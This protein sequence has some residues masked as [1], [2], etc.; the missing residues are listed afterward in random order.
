MSENRLDR[1]DVWILQA[2]QGQA[3]L[4]SAELAE[5]VA[6][7]PSPCWRRVKR[8]EDEGYIRGY[9]TELNPAKL[10]F[11]VTAFV[12][13]MLE[14]HR[15]DLGQEFEAAVAEVPQILSCHNVTGRYDFLL[16]VVAADLASF[17]DFARQVLR[18]LPGVKEVYSSFSLRETKAAGRLP[19]DLLLR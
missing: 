5:K 4:S 8:L 3:R 1:T 12:S 10:G 2:L 15:V 11:G 14:N 6:L 7:T 19:L 13:V 9:R 18:A 17:G 16:T